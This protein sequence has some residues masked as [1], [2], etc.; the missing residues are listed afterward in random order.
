MAKIKL[1]IYNDLG[2]EIG[3]RETTLSNGVETLDQIESSVELF[4]QS[5]LPE[6]TKVLLEDNQSNFKKKYTLQ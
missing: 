2:E 5:I 1:T 3:V 6:I 4:R